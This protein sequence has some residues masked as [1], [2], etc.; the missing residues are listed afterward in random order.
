MTSQIQKLHDLWLHF[1]Q[2]GVEVHM[3]SSQWFLTLYGTIS[4]AHTFHS[5][6]DV[7]TDRFT[8]KFP[9]PLVFRII[10][11]LLLDGEQSLVVHNNCNDSCVY[12]FV[13]SQVNTL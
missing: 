3:F 2:I 6:D 10:D 12:Y 1:Q 9:L 5:T 4:T 7:I 8:A 13:L 11:L